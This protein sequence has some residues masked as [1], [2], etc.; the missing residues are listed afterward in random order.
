MPYTDL[1][2]TKYIAA[3]WTEAANANPDEYLG[4][5]LFGTKKQMSL[6][7]KWLKGSGGVPISLA[8]SAFDAEIALRGRSGASKIETEM[9]LF[10]EG[11]QLTETDRRALVEAVALGE[12]Y[13]Q[14]ILSK[15]FNDSIALI[16]GAKVVPE[17]MIWQLLAPADGKPKISIA[18]DGV[19]YA[20]DYDPNG[21]WFANNFTDGSATPWSGA[22]AATPVDDIAKIGELAKTKGTALR[23]AIMSQK[24]MA[25]LRNSAQVKSLILSQNATPN[26]YL[27]DAAVKTAIETVTGIRPIVY[28]SVFKDESGTTKQFFPEKVVTFVPEGTLGD[29]VYATTSEEYELSGDAT[30]NVS[31]INNSIAVSTVCTSAMPPRIATYASEIVLPSY[32]RMDEVFEL[33]VEP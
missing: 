4:S 27:N 25:N 22:S 1:L 32:E 10:R 30:K 11:I 16:R 28:N 14:D 6:E 24:T 21:T 18:G 13:V 12:S 29:M 3:A 17:R 5:R 8:P 23:Y 20:Y 26:I 7:L 33:K 2:S 15:I 31:V 9:P 19:N